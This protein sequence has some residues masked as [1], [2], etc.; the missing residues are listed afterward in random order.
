MSQQPPPLTYTYNPQQITQ[1]PENFFG[2]D[3]TFNV[4]QYG[5]GNQM[6]YTNVPT[7]FD[8]KLVAPEGYD[9]KIR[10]NL[11]ARRRK[12]AEGMKKRYE[13]WQ[14]HPEKFKAMLDKRLSTAAIDPNDA[15][16][17][18]RQ[19]AHDGN[20]LVKRTIG[21]GLPD[22]AERQ[23]MK[24]EREARAVRM[25]GD[26]YTTPEDRAEA[27]RIGRRAYQAA[28]GRARPPLT[29]Q[30]KLARRQKEYLHMVYP[31]AIYPKN[32]TIKQ[33]LMNMK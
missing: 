19:Y 31:N 18:Y 33:S 9:D 11:M 3:M 29:P 30:E 5:T 6:A 16:K 14:A 15:L 27:I 12:R 24:E 20:K 32:E 26:K 17:R 28:S 13:D 23:R 1:R 22:A 25:F 7:V 8:E 21:K 2:D 4:P 10:E